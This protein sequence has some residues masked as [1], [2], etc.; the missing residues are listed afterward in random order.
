MDEGLKKVIAGVPVWVFGE[1]VSTQ[2]VARALAERPGQGT[3]WAVMAA[4]QR[5]GRGRGD[6]RWLSSP[7]DDLLVTVVWEPRELAAAGQFLL[8][9]ATALAVARTLAAHHPAVR[10]KWPNDLFAGGRKIAG[11]LLEHT[12]MGDRILRSYLGIGINLNERT[13]PPALPEAVSLAMLTG[14]HYDAETFLAAL[15]PPLLHELERAAGGEA[16]TLHQEYESWLLGFGE[17]QHFR[18]GRRHFT[19]VIEGVDR[20]GR[21]LLRHDDGTLQAAALDEVTLLQ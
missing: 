2:E 9:M 10:I 5:A 1:V 6:H 17:R 4:H 16:R 21:L 3:P 20:W 12:L 14:R 8:S 7:G 11:L 13:F 19:A 15:L 18:A